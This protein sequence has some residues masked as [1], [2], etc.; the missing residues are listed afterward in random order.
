MKSLRVSLLLAG[1]LMLSASTLSAQATRISCKDGSKPKV[2][3]FSCWGHGGLIR[4]AVNSAPKTEAKAAEKAAKAAEKPAKPEKAVEKS[5]KQK[6][7]SKVKKATGKNAHPAA[8]KAGKKSK[9][10]AHAKPSAK[11]GTA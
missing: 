6:S 8:A 10:K 5:K 2:G 3:H 7:P 4:E 11:S 9:K 1:M